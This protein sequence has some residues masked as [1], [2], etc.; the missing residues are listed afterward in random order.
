[1]L[2]DTV[3][4]DLVLNAD[5][6]IAVASDPYSLAQDAASEIRLFQGEAWYETT[7]GV[8]YWT[9]I[10]NQLPPLSLVKARITQAALLV[11]GVVAVQCFIS[12]FKDRN[13]SGQVQILD[14]A[15]VISTS[16]F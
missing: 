7:R 5:G 3:A 11:P 10:L 2:L 16:E 6:N 13:L 1:M 9:S 4:W 15:Q 14:K 8:P 12:S